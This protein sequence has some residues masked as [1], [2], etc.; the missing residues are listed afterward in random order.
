MYEKVFVERNLHN[1][2]S[3]SVRVFFPPTHLSIYLFRFCLFLSVSLLCHILCD[4]CFISSWIV[5][6]GDAKVLTIA[7]CRLN[8]AIYTRQVQKYFDFML[9]LRCFA[10]YTVAH[11]IENAMR[12]HLLKTKYKCVCSSFQRVFSVCLQPKSLLSGFFPFIYLVVFYSLAHSMSLVR[13]LCVY[14]FSLR[15]NDKWFFLVDMLES[16]R[17]RS[18]FGFC[19]IKI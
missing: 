13:C 7:S 2:A 4:F 6:I 11:C 3:V 18:V 16:H 15:P 14:V 17:E 9:S 8:K 1:F 12:T 5:R 10:L 19:V